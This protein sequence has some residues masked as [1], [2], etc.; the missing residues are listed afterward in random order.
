VDV[1]GHK[2]P[3]MQREPLRKITLDLLETYPNA[4]TATP[5]ALPPPACISQRPYAS[6]T[7]TARAAWNASTRCA[8]HGP[9]S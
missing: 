7:G 9:A 8:S 3:L 5:Y 1:K 2:E 6:A 4:A